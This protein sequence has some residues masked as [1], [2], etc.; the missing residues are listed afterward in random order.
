ME[1]LRDGRLFAPAGLDGIVQ[2]PFYRLMSENIRTNYLDDFAC[3]GI[4]TL[5]S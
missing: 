4:Q 5:F 1:L 2:R 3:N